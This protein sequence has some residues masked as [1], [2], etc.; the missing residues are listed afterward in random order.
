MDRQVMAYEI[1]FTHSR[2]SSLDSTPNSSISDL[3]VSFTR[4][5]HSGAPFL[6]TTFSP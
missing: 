4:S 3:D 6:L 2:A 1:A 5:S